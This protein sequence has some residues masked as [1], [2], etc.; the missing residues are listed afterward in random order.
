MKENENKRESMLII[1]TGMK[2]V[3]RTNYVPKENEVLIDIPVNYDKQ[4]EEPVMKI[5]REIQLYRH[6][7]DYL[8]DGII[9][10]LDG[11]I[12]DV[13][14]EQIGRLLTLHPTWDGIADTLGKGEVLDAISQHFVGRDVPMNG[15]TKEYIDKF[16]NDLK[17]KKQEIINFISPHTIKIN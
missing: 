10:L 13:T 14:D 9:D 7:L 11:I 3:G 12:E 16:Y 15:D 5:V 2:G 17:D 4:K 1:T 6:D 8:H